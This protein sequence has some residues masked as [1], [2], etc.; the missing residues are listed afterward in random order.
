MPRESLEG[1]RKQVAMMQNDLNALK[2]IARLKAIML[3][4]KSAL[5]M[6]ER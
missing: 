5:E 4:L 2:E 1:L 3:V 6:A